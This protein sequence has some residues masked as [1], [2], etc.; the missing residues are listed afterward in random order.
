MTALK[1]TSLA[2]RICNVTMAVVAL[3]QNVTQS[4]V[5]DV[6]NRALK[7]G[8]ALAVVVKTTNAKQRMLNVIHVMKTGIALVAVVSSIN[9]KT[10]MRSVL[11]LMIMILQIH[12]RRLLQVNQALFTLCMLRIIM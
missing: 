2:T 7:T 4:Q 9:A 5:G 8:N 11:E 3:I 1:K 12:G 10:H 6:Q